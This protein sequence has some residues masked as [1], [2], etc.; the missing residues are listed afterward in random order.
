MA[1]KSDYRA[2]IERYQRVN[3]LEI[4]ELRRRTPE[5]CL[6]QFS[7][8]MEQG[9][10]MNWQVHTPEEIAEVRRRWQKLKGYG[11]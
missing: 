11:G 6:R 10:S 3:E 4:E 1:K 2:Y 8:L 7:Y 5:E 9:L